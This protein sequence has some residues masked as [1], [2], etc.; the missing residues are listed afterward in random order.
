[1]L[2][3]VKLRSS[4]LLRLRTFIEEMRRY[5]IGYTKALILQGCYERGEYEIVTETGEIIPKEE[6]EN[7]VS[8]DEYYFVWML[9]MKYK[10]KSEDP[11]KEK[12]HPIEIEVIVSGFL[13]KHSVSPVPTQSSIEDV[14]TNG[15]TDGFIEYLKHFWHL[16]FKGM[17]LSVIFDEYEPALEEFELERVKLEDVK[18]VPKARIEDV[19]F[20]IRRKP[21]QDFNEKEDYADDLYPYV[22]YALQEVQQWI[23]D[24]EIIYYTKEVR[25]ELEKLKERIRKAELG[26]LERRIERARNVTDV[27]EIYDTLY[28]LYV[29]LRLSDEE[30]YELLEK[31]EKKAR[32]V[33]EEQRDRWIKRIRKCKSLSELDKVMWRIQ[34]TKTWQSRFFTPYREI[35]E[36]A[37]REKRNELLIEL[38]KKRKESKER[39]Y[40]RLET[41]FLNRMNEILKTTKSVRDLRRLITRVK[42]SKLPEEI[43]ERI[44]R[45]IHGKI[46]SIWINNYRYVVKTLKEYEEKLKE[47]EKLTVADLRSIE[48]K[49]RGLSETINGKP[50]NY[51]PFLSFVRKEIRR[52]RDRVK[53]LIRKKLTRVEEEELDRILKMPKDRRIEV[54]EKG[55]EESRT[56][57]ELMFWQKV[58]EKSRDF[59]YATRVR[60]LSKVRVK[61]FGG[62]GE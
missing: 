23:I 13:E 62:E 14:L 34:Q 48:G 40:K 31:L 16:T 29:S 2:E 26:K 36:E 54:I 15:L 57:D 49:L 43:K 52:L 42:R 58:I 18:Y 11:S 46:R 59:D 50:S 32:V 21:T 56:V 19:I 12:E 22:D 8:I 35:V 6:I 17:D 7:K 9:K 27:E 51:L 30:Y 4:G 10:S 38:I 47:E 3:L 44:V 55:I 24:S 37:E 28:D 61:L 60:L 33:F 53:Y 5:G 45:E 25:E 1:V 41:Y 20:R 39:I